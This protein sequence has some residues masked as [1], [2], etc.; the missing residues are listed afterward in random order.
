MNTATITALRSSLHSSRLRDSHVMLRALSGTS[1]FKILMI[2]RKE[3]AGLTP[4]EIAKVLNVSL[5]RV[6]HQMRILRDHDLVTVTENSREAIYRL[7]S[8]QLI[9][10]IV[11]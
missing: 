9:D 7:R 1:R 5:S 10:R 3:P 8:K 4:T 11:N 2:L 6:S